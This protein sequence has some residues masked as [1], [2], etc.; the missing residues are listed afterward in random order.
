MRSLGFL[1]RI[2]LRTR[3][4][5]LA[6][7]AVAGL[8]FIGTVQILSDSTVSQVTQDRDTAA[9][10]SER[11]SDFSRRILAVRV[12]EQRLRA[13]RKASTLPELARV[14]E[15]TQSRLPAVSAWASVHEAYDAYADA[16]ATYKETLALLG[17]RDRQ[18]VSV[19]EEGQA[20]IDSPT[21]YTVD[22]SN[23]ASRI[24]ARIGEELEFDDQAAVYAVAMTFERVQR[25]ITKL[26][27]ES[28]TDYI[29]F[30]ETKLADLVSLLES[31]DLDSSF[32][33]DLAPLAGSLQQSLA[34]L[35][36]AERELDTALTAINANYEA[37]SS[38]LD[39]ELNATSA[40]L[41][42]ADNALKQT[43]ATAS[44]L[45]FF[46]VAATLLI[47]L[48]A[49]IAIVRSVSGN[50]SSITAATEN[51]ANGDLQA[52]I[53]LTKVNTEVGK[54]A[55]ALV[56]FRDNAIARQELEGVARQENAAKAQ[57]QEVVETVIAG[58]RQDIV[59]LL[60]AAGEAVSK[61]DQLASDLGQINEQNAVEAATASEASIHASE[62]VETVA[63]ATQ[64]LTASISE[65]SK[66]I[67]LSSDQI[68]KVNDNARTTND[69]VDGLARAATKIDE[70][71]VLIQAIAEQTNLLALN[72]TIEAARAGEHGKGFAVVAAEVKELATQTSRATEE[73]SSQI[74]EIQQSSQA[75]VTAIAG[76]TEIISEVQS[77]TAAIAG[78]VEEQTAATG[79]I[80]QNIG[81]A[82][83]RTRGMAHNVSRLQRSA[84]EASDSSGRI[85]EASTDI[86]E[87]NRKVN[88]RI[89]TFLNEVS[90]A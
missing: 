74:K 50:L 70:I 26:I 69:D 10:A 7:S 90:A 55:R 85:R 68:R 57:R 46:A 35:G 5:A 51:L 2:T 38:A 72:A 66:Q 62:N 18:S 39:S 29:G 79:E 49:S 56:V 37:L 73:I 19:A 89:E 42:A 84:V 14:E 20:G 34:T 54:L 8:L 87:I 31:E 3:V 80:S 88:E 53:P 6:I 30:V 86:E 44:R 25:D 59:S 23:A 64:Q 24:G 76:I 32:A 63:A 40:A 61:A 65:I 77:T 15:T 9:A 83:E 1:N 21:G 52:E 27:A 36:D 28:D 78:A 22:V 16:I 4:L 43:R 45:I 81:Q 82:A 13:E 58:F 12:A 47:L 67:S 41:S 17:Y 11:L 75:T 71:I 33:E 48:V 60:T